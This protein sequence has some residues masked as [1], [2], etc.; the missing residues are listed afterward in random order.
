[1]HLAAMGGTAEHAVCA[2]LLLRYGVDPMQP[3][4]GGTSAVELARASDTASVSSLFSP[5]P[6]EATRDCCSL[7]VG[8]PSARPRKLELA[9]LAS[10]GS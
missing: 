5:F 9:L 7:R 3:D 1:L 8:I 10:V 6:W 2:N 4:L